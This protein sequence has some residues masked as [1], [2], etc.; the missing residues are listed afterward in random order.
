MKE[1][2]R[3][4]RTLY[5][6]QGGRCESCN[7]LFTLEDK[8]ELAH[9]IP[10]YKFNYAE[11]GEDVIDHIFNLALTHTGKCNDKQN[12]SL[13]THPIQGKELIQAI[14]NDILTRS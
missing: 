3:K 12:L 11:Y 1:Y 5:H 13:A 2:N 10:A 14:K 8:K 4:V 7:T 9:K 6:S